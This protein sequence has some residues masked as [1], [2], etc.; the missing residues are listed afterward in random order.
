[1]DDFEL[2]SGW[3]KAS[4]SNPNGAC[5]ETASGFR[6]SS[7]SANNGACLEAGTGGAR[8]VL[9]RDSKYG[10]RG[11]VSPVLA[12]TPAAWQSFTLSLKGT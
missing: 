10:L 6:K 11:Q 2:T 4:A 8:H 3:R 5:V 12:F 1:M 7:A 9:V